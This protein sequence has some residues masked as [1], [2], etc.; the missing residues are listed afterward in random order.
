M[1]LGTRDHLPIRYVPAPRS[2]GRVTKAGWRVECKCGHLTPRAE[3][4]PEAVN[5]YV[6][7]EQAPC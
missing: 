4:K 1:K 6:E 7:H 5:L 3:S 2:S